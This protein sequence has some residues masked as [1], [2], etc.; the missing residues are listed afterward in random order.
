MRSDR[1]DDALDFVHCHPGCV[2]AKAD[3]TSFFGSIASDPQ[4]YPLTVFMWDFRHGGGLEPV[5]D[6]RIP[7]GLRSAPEICCRLARLVLNALRRRLA[8]HGISL[9]PREDAHC[10]NGVDDWHVLA[11][12]MA[13]CRDIW[14]ELLE[15]LRMLGFT[16][17]QKPHK[18]I[19]PCLEIPWLG[20]L[21]DTVQCTV[22][23]PL[24]KLQKGLALLAAMRE[25]GTCRSRK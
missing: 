17:N 11:I 6:M 4:D 14:R 22:F 7:F 16:V 2:A 10:S 12:T 19:A 5:V 25:R 21:L 1:T 20:L 13:M 3:L 18:L 23:L 9:G 15:L 24:D 8:E